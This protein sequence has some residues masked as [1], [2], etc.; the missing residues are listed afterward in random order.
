[1]APLKRIQ[2]QT[3]A[4]IITGSLTLSGVGAIAGPIRARPGVGKTTFLLKVA[5]RLGG[6]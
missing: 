6:V 4:E 1:M 3:A 2:A 5:Q